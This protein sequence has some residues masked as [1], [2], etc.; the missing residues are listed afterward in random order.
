MLFLDIRQSQTQTTDREDQV[1]VVSTLDAV[2][3]GAYGCI[4]DTARILNKRK[5]K[6]KS[7]FD[8]ENTNSTTVIR[9]LEVESK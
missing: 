7:V 6:T 1:V 8:L 2:T 5:K 9:K 4:Y 3:F